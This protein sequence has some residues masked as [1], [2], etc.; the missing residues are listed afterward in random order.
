M[1]LQKWINK[2]N[3]P[4]FFSALFLFAVGFLQWFIQNRSWEQ[5]ETTLAQIP[6]QC[7]LKQVLGIQCAFCGMTHA[8]LAI[9][10]GEWVKAFQFNPLGPFLF[11]VTGGGAVLI[12]FG[13]DPRRLQWFQT[14]RQKQVFISVLLGSLILFMVWRNLN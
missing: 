6:Y 11:G 13:F 14:Q 7:P 8:W 2:I 9:L 1:V 12:C 5:I 10:K 4:R 3:I